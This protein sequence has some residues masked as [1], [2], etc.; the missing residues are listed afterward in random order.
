MHKD[1]EKLITCDGIGKEAKKKIIDRLTKLDLTISLKRDDSIP[2]F[3]AFFR[4]E[5]DHGQTPEIFLNV[6]GVMLPVEDEEGNELRQS[7]EDR[8]R[9]I[10]TTLM[11]EIGHALEAHFRLPINEEHIERACE[12]WDSAYDNS[13]L[14]SGN[15]SSTGEPSPTNPT[16][17]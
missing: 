3:G 13:K 9:L 4:C 11:H 10:I 12:E 7:A 16:C 2:A 14:L 6:A 17:P 1:L 15:E 8:T 5:E